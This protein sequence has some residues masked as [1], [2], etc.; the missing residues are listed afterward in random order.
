MF[1]RQPPLFSEPTTNPC[2]CQCFA[3]LRVPA[4]GPDLRRFR[5]AFGNIRHRSGWTFVSE[6]VR[7]WATWNVRAAVVESTDKAT[8]QGFVIDH[9][10]ASTAGCGTECRM[11]RYNSD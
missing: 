5:T 3:K 7:V 6:H 1:L 10:V 11:G 8:L 2:V 4:F 9:T